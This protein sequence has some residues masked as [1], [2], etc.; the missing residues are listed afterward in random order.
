MKAGVVRVDELSNIALCPSWIEKL[1][2][3]ILNDTWESGWL[4][5]LDTENKFCM[6]L[7]LREQI[8]RNWKRC[9]IGW[10]FDNNM[11]YRHD[12][13]EDQKASFHI[14]YDE[15]VNAVDGIGQF[16]V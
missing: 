14:M 9:D 2:Q 5:A 10:T 3:V 12:D 4:T 1:P 16:G 8:R 11:K 13:F 15:R 6:S 7:H